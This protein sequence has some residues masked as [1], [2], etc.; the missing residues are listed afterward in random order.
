MDE[1]FTAVHP[2]TRH[3][4]KARTENKRTGASMGRVEVAVGSHGR[5]M[6]STAVGCRSSTIF[7]EHVIAT[8]LLITVTVFA[9]ESA[10][11]T[12]ASMLLA[13]ADSVVDVT[14]EHT[15]KASDEDEDCIAEGILRHTV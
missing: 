1:V 12:A 8:T 15:T 10:I 9:S 6:L 11:T 13:L 2:D 14:A 3:I 4:V 7:D 5:T